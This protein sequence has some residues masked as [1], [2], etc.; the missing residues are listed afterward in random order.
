MNAQAARIFLRAGILMSPLALV[1]C[2][3]GDGPSA[4]T[5]PNPAVCAAVGSAPA[6]ST[7]NPIVE[8]ANAASLFTTAP[9]AVTLNAG[10]AVTYGVGGGTPPYTAT[11]GNTNVGKASMSGTT[12]SLSSVAAGTSPVVVVDAVGKTVNIALTVLAQGQAGAALSVAPGAL[13]IGNCTTNV[14]FIFSGGIPPYTIFT[15][16]NF[17]VPVSSPLMLDGVLGSYYFTATIQ[18]KSPT[19]GG[20]ATLTVLDSQSRSETVKVKTPVSSDPCPLNPLLK[21]FPESANFRASEM[22]SFQVT[23]GSTP[24]KAPTVSF[25]DPSVAIYVPVSETEFKVQAVES[26][27]VPRTTLMTVATTDGQR[28]SV[29]ITVM[30]QP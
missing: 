15:S 11:S 27:T 18:Y 29:V 13:T 7:V 1:A 9:T 24:A 10:T 26:V 30:P 12:L 8:N 20:E 5:S 21:V 2:G 28:A 14:P 4:C 25:A 23:G 6:S 17:G 19:S 16:D 3:G 22:R